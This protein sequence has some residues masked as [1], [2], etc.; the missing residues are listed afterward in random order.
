[1]LNIAGDGMK[2][3]R[4][5]GLCLL[6]LCAGLS[7]VWGFS[8]KHSVSTRHLDFRL[9]Y[10]ASRGMLQGKSPYQPGTLEQI[11]RAETGASFPDS[12]TREI[13]TIFI[14]P[15]TIFSV[16][17]P[18]ALLP[19][20]LAQQ[21]WFLITLGSFLVAITLMWSTGVRHTSVLTIVLLCILAANCEVVFGTENAAGLAV[22]LCVIAVWCLLQEIFV[23]LGVFFL[24]VSLVIK[25]HDAGMVW[26]FFVL[27]GKTHRRR[28]WKTLALVTI[29][30]APALLWTSY[31]YPDWAHDLRANLA[32]LSSPGNL[33][34]PGPS[35]ISGRTGNMI[36][37]LQAL[38]S[39]FWDKPGFYNP[40][41]YIIC[42]AMLLLWANRLRKADLSF[43]Q[44]WLA[45]GAV[46][47]LTMLVTYHRTYDAKLIMLII[48]ACAML[49]AK[50]DQIAQWAFAITTA[51]VFFSADIPLGMVLA[52]AEKLH[53]APAGIVQS[54]LFLALYRF[55][56]LLLLAT[57]IFYLWVFLR[58]RSNHR[59]AAHH[60]AQRL[61]P[62]VPA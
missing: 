20:N 36:I 22:N 33:N 4:I 48:P 57:S 51:T 5:S 39:V 58:S 56:P 15:P 37:S 38:L 12:A 46:V 25:P 24:A 2:W 41:T 55:M 30:S 50:G 44:A 34:D 3:T 16:V 29:L 40:A 54:V 11:Y 18:L 27:A 23:P 14:Y 21:V 42:G 59:D 9:V 62:D 35:S 13:L 7:A 53:L 31:H 1:M 60:E 19:W 61:A 26:L 28:A 10:L 32:S 8:L 45:I 47:P 17:A 6:L 43:E 52:F 49:F